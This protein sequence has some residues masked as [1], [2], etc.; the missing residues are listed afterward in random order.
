VIVG[1]FWADLPAE[2][3]QG[4]NLLVLAVLTGFGRLA[5]VGF[6]RMETA[7]SEVHE[8][9]VVAAVAAVSTEKAVNHQP[10]GTPPIAVQV[11]EIAEMLRPLAERMEEVATEADRKH[12]ETQAEM[13]RLAKD[14]ANVAI[15]QEMINRALGVDPKPWNPSMG[16][17]R[18]TDW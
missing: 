10:E 8:T 5:Y 12:V 13:S 11:T 18:R 7:L 3:R 15:S 6:R 9:A 1:G 14:I 2:W 17:R 4:V 16:D